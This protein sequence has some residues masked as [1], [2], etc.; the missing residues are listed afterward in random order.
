MSYDIV[1]SF[2]MAARPPVVPLFRVA[3]RD[4]EK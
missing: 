4:K 1:K 3:I 2:C